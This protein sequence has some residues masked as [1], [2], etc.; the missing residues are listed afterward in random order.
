MND[1][2]YYTLSE[3]EAATGIKRAT[4]RGR[5]MIYGIPSP[6]SRG[7]K[8]YTYEEV[9]IIQTRPKRPTAM[10][11]RRVNDLKKR[12]LNDGFKVELP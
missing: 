2:T 11:S 3:I 7:R 10:D 1:E 4:I 8:G 6:R 12:L 9:K 5:A